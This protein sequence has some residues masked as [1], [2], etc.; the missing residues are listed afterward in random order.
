MNWPAS[1]SSAGSARLRIGDALRLGRCV[2]A[3]TLIAQGASAQGFGFGAG[4]ELD[5][6]RAQQQLSRQHEIALANELA[7]LESRVST[8][9]ALQ[10][11]RIPTLRLAPT[12]ESVAALAGATPTPPL[13]SDAFLAESN[14]RVRAAAARRH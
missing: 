12:I 2:A 14:R 7:A 1:A 10:D 6:L 13:I 3:L 11:L 5:Q 4:L 9:Q 8:E